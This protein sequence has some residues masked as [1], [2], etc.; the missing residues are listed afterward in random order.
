MNAF[1]DTQLYS[2]GDNGRFYVTYI[3]Q[4]LKRKVC[5]RHSWFNL[6]DPGSLQHKIYKYKISRGEVIPTGKPT[7]SLGEGS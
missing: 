1:N 5:D 6:M 2:Y 4:Q 7:Q 3:Y